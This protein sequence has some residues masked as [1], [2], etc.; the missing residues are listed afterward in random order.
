MTAAIRAAT[1]DDAPAIARA[2]VAAWRTAYRGIVPDAHLE[3]LCETETAPRWTEILA[4]RDVFTFVA[5][6]EA[7]D[8]VGFANGGPERTGQFEFEGELYAIYLLAEYRGQGIGTRLFS[9][10]A[11]TLNEAGTGGMMVWVLDANPYRRFYERMGGRLLDTVRTIDIGGQPFA[12][13]AY[14]W[15][16]LGVIQ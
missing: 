10:V 13:A 2:R 14:G 7:G 6:D 11:Q 15:S 1:L 16:D 9:T 4:Q 12:E 8:V 5:V 3:S